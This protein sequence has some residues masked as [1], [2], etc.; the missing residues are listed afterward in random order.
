MK[1][2]PLISACEYGEHCK[3]PR[4]AWDRALAKIE[5]EQFSFKIWHLV[6]N[7]LMIF[8]IF[9]CTILHLRLHILLPRLDKIGWTARLDYALRRSETVMPKQNKFPITFRRTAKCC[10]RCPEITLLSTRNQP[11][12]PG[13]TAQTLITYNRTSRFWTQHWVKNG[14]LNSA[15]LITKR[16]AWYSLKWFCARFSSDTLYNREGRAVRWLPTSACS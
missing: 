4:A 16:Y 12:N 15:E 7:I 3:L 13:P 1:N 14:T 10:I 11:S 9:D 5:L 8:P 6:T 2:K